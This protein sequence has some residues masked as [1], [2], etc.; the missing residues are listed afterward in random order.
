MQ[1]LIFVEVMGD[2]FVYFVV[3]ADDIFNSI[4]LVNEEFYF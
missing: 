4:F 1:F 3:V 2:C